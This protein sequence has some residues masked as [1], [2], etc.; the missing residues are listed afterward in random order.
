M[1]F[2][3]ISQDSV[4]AFTLVLLRVG[5]LVGTMPLFGEGIVPVRAKV[6]LSLLIALL[7]FP[8]V[9]PGLPAVPEPSIPL[10][11]RMVSEILIGVTLGFAARLVFAA[12]QV[13]GE[14]IG[15]KIGFSVANVI[16]P[17]SSI[18][19]SLIGQF[20]Y[21]LAVLIFL[22]TNSHHVFFAAIADSFRIV[23]LF[24][25]HLSG[26]LMKIILDLSRDMFVLAVKI[27]IPVVA[28]IMFTNVGLGIVARTVPQINVLIVGFPLQIMIGLVFFGLS[29]PLF[30]SL[31]QQAFGRLG[32]SVYS[33]LKVM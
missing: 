1:D 27:C 6:G 28:A 29:M 26:D 2:P 5:S 8:T 24:T 10:L 31:L 25:F 11:F 23:P 4:I 14:M 30:A 33:L 22:V 15:F 20:Q 7:L 16:D 21:L 9:S 19:I 3:V 32:H 17:I 12:A 13:A 18:Q